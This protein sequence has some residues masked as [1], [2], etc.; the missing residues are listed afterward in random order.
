MADEHGT[1]PIAMIPVAAARRPDFASGRLPFLGPGGKPN[2]S[3]LALGSSVPVWGFAMPSLRR[4]EGPLSRRAVLEVVD[5]SGS[6][7]SPDERPVR[8][9]R[10]QYRWLGMALQLS[11]GR[12]AA[13]PM[14]STDS[15]DR[16]VAASFP[17]FLGACM[18][19]SMEV[20]FPIYSVRGISMRSDDTAQTPGCT[21]RHAA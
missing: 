7:C 20:L 1:D 9:R 21:R 6:Y 16:L 18:A 19:E 4:A 17:D 5:G 8:P 12:N 10:L 11:P 3:T 15:V 2:F 14:V 13:A